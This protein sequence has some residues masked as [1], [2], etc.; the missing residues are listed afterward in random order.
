MAWA[1]SIRSTSGQFAKYPDEKP[2][3]PSD[4]VY[5]R[6]TNNDCQE[7]CMNTETHISQV[8]AVEKDFRA[9]TQS[10]SANMGRTMLLLQQ[11]LQSNNV[12]EAI[13]RDISQKELILVEDGPAIYIPE[14]SIIARESNVTLDYKFGFQDNS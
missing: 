13:A 10:L 2:V 4:I 3:F 5:Y 12:P 8:L 14:D 11:I 1:T 9:S 6:H 7:N